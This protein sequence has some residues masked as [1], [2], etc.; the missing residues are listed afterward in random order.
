MKNLA[1]IKKLFPYGIVAL[2][3]GF[4]MMAFE[5]VAARLLAPTIGS[6]TFIWTNVI[7]VIIAALSI[8]YWQGGI[9]ADKRKNPADIVFLCLSTALAILLVMI[10]HSHIITLAAQTVSDARI[11]G[12]LAAIGLFALPSFG[13]GMISPYLVKF[14]VLSTATSGSSV[15]NLSAL[16]AIGSIIGTFI[17]GF[18]LFGLIGSKATLFFIIILLV[19]TS[20]LIAPKKFWG[21]RIALSAIVVGLSILSL[22]PWPSSTNPK[23][24]DTASASYIIQNSTAFGQPTTDLITGPGGTQ[25]SVY[26]T[27]DKDLVFWYT[28]V[29]VEAISELPKS[30][31]RILI[32]GGGAYTLPEYLAVNYP[33]SQI[34]TVEIDPELAQISQQYFRFEPQPNLEI[35]STDART[36]VNNTAQKY[37]A[38]IIDTY[39]DDNTPWQFVTAEFGQ[40]T[41]D[42]LNDG[43]A[44]LA[45]AIAARE[46]NCAPLFA[47][48]QAA[49][50]SFLN[51]GYSKNRIDLPDARS[52][53]IMVFSNQTLALSDFGQLDQP[54]VKPYTDDFAPIEHLQQQCKS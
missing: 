28:R 19:A 35:T 32:L 7:G 27:G 5:L 37:D 51:H 46:G 40:K 31:Q 1:K 17:T 3:T 22:L 25:S 4:T 10:F 44:V 52:N 36:F 47:A 6:S 2:T 23:T 21:P 33:D 20:W 41:A 15:A 8:G 24:I 30:P 14:S 26:Q 45:N 54:T 12:L 13:L 34:D 11:Q 43:G 29:L 9:V 49:Y 38:I 39:S 50:G 53:I 48:I 42:S 16:N 18:V